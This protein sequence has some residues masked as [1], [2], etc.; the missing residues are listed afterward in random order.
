MKI[1]E[2]QAGMQVIDEK[3]RMSNEFG[4]AMSQILIQL[5]HFLSDNGYI[6]PGIDSKTISLIE[7]KEIN[8]QRND[9]HFQPLIAH[10]SEKKLYRVNDVSADGKMLALQTKLA[11][12]YDHTKPWI[13][14]STGLLSTYAVNFL[15]QFVEEQSS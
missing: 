10:D 4:M 6:L 13:D 9:K 12:K 11:K 2:I 14:V 5:R 1:Q 3:G 15:N 7:K 8:G